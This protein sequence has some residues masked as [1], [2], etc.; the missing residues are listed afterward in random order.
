MENYGILGKSE[1]CMSA[2]QVPK[3][4]RILSMQY[5]FILKS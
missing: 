3:E 4:Y 5:I 1:L 2:I